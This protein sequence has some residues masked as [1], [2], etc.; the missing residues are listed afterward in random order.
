MYELLI[1]AQLSTLM[2]LI[3]CSGIA[4]IQASKL[5]YSK[6]EKQLNHKTRHLTFWSV[7]LSLLAAVY[8]LLATAV[9]PTIGLAQLLVRTSLTAIPVSLIWL[10]SAPRLR[11]LVRRTNACTPLMPDVARRR[12]ATDPAFIF[13]YQLTA[14]CSAS[15]LY[16]AAVPA[17]PFQWTAVTIPATL[18]L[19]LSCLL[20]LLQSHRSQLAAEAAPVYHPWRFRLAQTALL[21]SLLVISK[22]LL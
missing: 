7:S 4:A 10:T 22:L 6:S 13:P 19:F 15:L 18:L 12:Q 1:Y 2:L 16:L 3:V 17:I 20:W 11:K 5:I 9:H 8:I 14:L 21:L